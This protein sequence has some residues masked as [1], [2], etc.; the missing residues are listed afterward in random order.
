MRHTF[1]FLAALLLAMTGRTEPVRIVVDVDKPGHSVPE[2]LYGIFFEEINHSGEGGLYAEMVL[3][4]DFEMT[5]LPKGA[6]WAGNLLLTS[7]KWW[8]RK[9]FGNQLWGWQFIADGGAHG[10]IKLDDREPL[11]ERNPHS[12]RLTVREPGA[13]AGVVNG[14]FWGM[15]FGTNCWYDLTFQARTDGAERFDVTVVLESANGRECYASDVVRDVGGAWKEYR[16]SLQAKAGDR[17][18]RLAL[19]VNHGG[20]IWFDVVSLFPRDTFKG[21]PNGLRLDLVQALADLK[22]AFVRFPGGAIVGGLNLGNRIQWKNSIGPVTQRKG[23]M[24]LWGYWTS[25]GLGFHEY[26]QFCEDIGAAA[27]WVCNPGFSDN[28]RHAEYAPPEQI[29]EF[30]QEALDGIE[31]AIGPADSKWGA[32]RAANGHPAPFPLRYVEI[33]NEASGQVYRT[34]YVQFAEAIRS[35]YPAITIISNQRLKD[36]PV[37]VVDDHKYGSPAS[38]FKDYRRYD[39]ADRSGPKVY[40]G[41]Y[42]CTEG[43]GEGNLLAALS[44]AVFLLGLERNSDVVTMSSYAPLL[45][46]A[47]DIAWPVNLIGFDNSRVVCRSSYYV[48]KMLA[49]NRPDVVLPTRVEPEV[50]PKDSELFALAGLDRQK[51][52][53]L[54]KIV[55]RAASPRPVMI[56]LNGSG[57]LAKA[58]QVITIS[59]D[60]PSAENTLDEPD[61]IL[62]REAVCDISGSEFLQTLPANS[63]TVLRLGIRQK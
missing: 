37:D 22:P 4:R 26:L 2:T 34:N 13:R 54:L 58:A 61:L 51:E 52:T 41:E 17:S 1:I 60:D 62:P 27:L 43:V 10:S 14:G 55:N 20:T 40:V 21:R 63:L 46:H 3:N 16:V 29:R 38:F 11:N 45:F 59:H 9:W 28:Y 57:T 47:N 35:K 7:D 36:A 49:S 42:G 15:N 31:Y 8:E 39:S 6:K 48:Q 25:N 56:R 23:T 19:T 44:E 12:M 50:E 5:S 53:I 32:Q 33:G 18:G 30:V 24:N